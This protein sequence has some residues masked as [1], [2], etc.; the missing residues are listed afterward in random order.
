M[1][2]SRKKLSLV[3]LLTILAASFVAYAAIKYTGTV[4]NTANIKGYKIA[5][6]NTLTNTPIDAIPWGDLD[7]NIVKTTETIF[8]SIHQIKMKN[9]GNYQCFAA[10]KM[11]DTLPSGVTLLCDYWQGDSEGNWVPLPQNDYSSMGAIIPNG[12]NLYGLR[13]SLNAATGAAMGSFNFTIYLLGA[14]SASG[15]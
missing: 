4:T 2:I 6:W 9:V 12:F 14:D 5:L 10:W 1:Q 13:W 7:L 15:N 11:N 8:A 3:V